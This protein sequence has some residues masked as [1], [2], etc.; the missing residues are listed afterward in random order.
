MPE[1]L[2][3]PNFTLGAAYPE[4]GRLRI[5]LPAADFATV[6]T[7]F[8]GLDTNATSL[9][10][11][12][13][14]DCGGID[15]ALRQEWEA[16]PDDPLIGTL[17]AANLIRVGW[18][19]RSYALAKYVSQEQFQGFRA[20]LCQ[21]EQVLID[22][23]ARHPDY[24]PAWT[25]RLTSARG[26]SLGQSELRRRYDRLAAHDPHHLPA[27]LSM[28]QKLCPKWGGSWPA[29]QAFVKECADAAPPGSH[30]AVLVCEGHLEYMSMLD[31]KK[32]AREYLQDP[33][34]RQE[35]YAAAESSVWHPDFV[36]EFGWVWVRATF[37][38]LF[39]QMGDHRA[40]LTQF[41]ALEPYGHA[42]WF[43]Y[44][45]NEQEFVRYRAEAYAKG[46]A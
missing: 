4:I 27:Q 7:I 17:L 21:A 36:H 11:G 40:A 31:T 10:I 46:A 16:H 45:G 39:S 5:A 32:E 44:L 25:E 42:G 29:V 19:V 2:P 9:A 34:V 1:R 30:N 26:L 23:T 13:A 43:D 35:I 12:A 18:K 38:S 24:V 28:L 14:T 41:K 37:A 22:V 33:R 15:A 8:A 20:Y 3:P 6:R